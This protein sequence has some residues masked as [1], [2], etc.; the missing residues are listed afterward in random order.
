M[1]NFENINDVDVLFFTKKS[2]EIVFRY[3]IYFLLFL[4]LIVDEIIMR[5]A[6]TKEGYVSFDEFLAIITEIEKNPNNGKK[7]K[8]HPI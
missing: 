4:I 7:G 1:I 5:I 6:I 2:E 8:S 3:I